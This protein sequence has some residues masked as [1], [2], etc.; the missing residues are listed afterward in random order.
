MLYLDTSV[1]IALVTAEPRSAALRDWAEAVD[2]VFV[3]SDW[4]LTEVASGLSIKQRT[5]ALTERERAVVERALARFLAENVEVVGVHRV[6]YRTAARLSA[7]PTPPL[8]AADA[9][10]LAVADRH[11]AVLHTLDDQQAAGARAH[12]IGAVVPVPRS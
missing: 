4:S 7:Q 2:D 1:L 6:D 8:R 12:D 5:G 11:G 9:L 10:H 3:T